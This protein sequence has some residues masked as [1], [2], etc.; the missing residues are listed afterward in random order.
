VAAD[1]TLRAA[2]QRYRMLFD[3]AAEGVALH[4]LVRDASGQV[5][6]YRITAVNQQYET[7]VGLP[8]DRVVGQLATEVYGTD[9]PAYLAEFSSAPLTGRPLRFDTYF[10]PLDRYFSISVAPIGVN[11]FATIF[12]DV[13]ELR[14]AQQEHERLSALVESSTEFVGMATLDGAVTYV[15]AAGRRLTGIGK[16][17]PLTGLSLLDLAPPESRARLA[18]RVLPAVR[19]HGIW[20]GESALLDR[21]TQTTVPVD[22]VSF[23][24]RSRDGGEPLCLSTIMRDNRERIRAR[25]HRE[26]LEA[27]LRQAQKM[28][29]IGRL[30]GGVA[31]DFNNLLTSILG[32]VEL[33]LEDL[34]PADPVHPYLADVRKA[35]ESAAALT[36]Q[37]LAFSRKQ[38]I[39][40]AVINLNDVLA[41]LQR[42]LKRIIGEDVA[43]VASP[44]PS[45][46]CVFADAGQ[47]EQVIVNLAVNGR[48]AMPAGGRLTIAS[49]NV[50][51]G[52]E[53]GLQSPD[54][55]PGPHV[56]LSVSDTGVGMDEETM[57]HVFEPFFTTKKTGTGLGLATVYGAVVQNGGFVT[58]NS[59]VGAGTTFDIFLPAVDDLP[60]PRAAATRVRQ[61]RGSGTVL[62]VE[63]E[64]LVRDLARRALTSSGYLV[65]AC[66]DGQ[67][68]M[69]VAA[70][71]DGPIDLLL[72]DVVMPGMNGR[73]LAERLTAERPGT[74]V[75]FT[76][77]HTGDVIF[78]HGV[79]EEGL[80]FLAKPYTLHALAEKVRSILN[81]PA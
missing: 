52:D 5:V 51:V 59:R 4:E 42:M 6:N 23:L 37:L 50:F 44:E 55:R 58:V 30:A 20:K 69:S 67:E 2:E 12:F 21:E 8:A 54:A 18:E 13:T 47:M 68:A 36:R 31:H 66:A 61:V 64:P 76:S 40:P 78:R 22:V 41:N 39:E 17:E 15:N 72:T 14:K 24:V 80:D 53:L 60:T 16:D 62:L 75:L 29:S 25:E 28:E 32:N 10:P 73:E 48:D 79:V 3:H 9:E 38:L 19:E 1:E 33:A 46:K 63:D 77:G 56:R 70:R 49:S 35:G 71:H 45:L 11:G 81:R 7:I 34:N 26:R 27:Q 43:L 57:A 65:V 74:K